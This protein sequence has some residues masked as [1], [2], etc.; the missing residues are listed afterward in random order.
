MNHQQDLILEV[1]NL[2]V[3]FGRKNS[4]VEVTSDVSFSLHRGEIL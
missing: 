2:S 3:G 1:E 4:A